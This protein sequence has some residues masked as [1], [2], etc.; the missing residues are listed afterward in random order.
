[1]FKSKSML[2]RLVHINYSGQMFTD[3]KNLTI[4]KEYCH[5]LF[6]NGG[7]ITS[8][9]IESTACKYVE[10]EDYSESMVSIE[11]GFSGVTKGFTIYIP[12]GK[13]I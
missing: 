8:A 6:E 2:S 1:M 12:K 13:K 3:N 11:Y 7:I 4:L 9:C 5:V 10:T